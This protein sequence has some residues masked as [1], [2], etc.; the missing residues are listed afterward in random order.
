MNA[1]LSA[2]NQEKALVGENLR[3]PSFEALQDTQQPLD[4]SVGADLLGRGAGAAAPRSRCG[5]GA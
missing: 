2:F 1:L 4:R 5:R 3:E